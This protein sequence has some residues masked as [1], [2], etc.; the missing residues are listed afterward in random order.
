MSWAPHH[1]QVKQVTTVS[2]PARLVVQRCSTF[3]K[4][5]LLCRDNWSFFGTR[6]KDTRK[7]YTSFFLWGWIVS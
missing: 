4:L 5:L 2:A 1:P 6:G 3:N 7:F